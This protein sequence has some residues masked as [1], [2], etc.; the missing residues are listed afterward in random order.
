MTE[1]GQQFFSS[2][3]GDPNYARRRLLFF[4]SGG[5]DGGMWRSRRNSFAETADTHLYFAMHL[6][7]VSVAGERVDFGGRWQRFGCAVPWSLDFATLGSW[8]FLQVWR[9]FFSLL[10]SG[11]S[12]YPYVSSC[13]RLAPTKLKRSCALRSES[14][15]KC[16]KYI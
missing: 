2:T 13:L 6:V 5:G 3:T 11:T 7:L 14:T 12:S 16:K 1:L 4:R 15:K 9:F 8:N 10:I